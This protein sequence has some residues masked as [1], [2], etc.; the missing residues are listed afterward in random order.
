MRSSCTVFL[1]IVLADV[2]FYPHRILDL[3]RRFRS[4]SLTSENTYLLFIYSR[5][6]ASKRKIQMILDTNVPILYEIIGVK[7]HFIAS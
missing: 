3:S 1:T 2:Y 7:L 5:T 6:R 4:L